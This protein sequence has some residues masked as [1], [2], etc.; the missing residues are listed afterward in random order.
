MKLSGC[1]AATVLAF[2]PSSFALLAQ[3]AESAAYVRFDLDKTRGN[4]FRS[5]EKGVMPFG[6]L[7]KR[8]DEYVDVKIHNEQTFY[9]VNLSI[10]TPAQ[11]VTVLVDTG[12]SD[13]WIIGADVDC[14]PDN[15]DS[16]E[17]LDCFEYGAFD[18][19]KSSSWKNNH[20]EFYISYGD[21]SFA[22]GEWGTDKLDLGDLNADGLTFAVATASNS[23][24]AV[25]GIGLTGIEVTRASGDNGYEYD[26]LPIVLKRNGVID[27]T[28]YSLYLNDLDATSG[29]VLFG[30]VDHSKYTGTLATVPLVN[31]NARY[32]FPKPIELHITLNGL[33]FSSGKKRGT[34]SATK[35]PAL[36]DS[37]TTLSY[38][39]TELAAAI[40]SN[41]GAVWNARLRKFLI[42]CSQAKRN[43]IDLI[44][45]FGGVEITSPLVNYLSET[46]VEDVCL[47]GIVP[48]SSNDIILG[49]VFL[50][51]VYTVYDL[52]A[53]E[54]SIAQAAY[55]ASAEKENIEV[56]KST[57]PG[58]TKAPGYSN[59]WSTYAPISTGGN[60]FNA[61]ANHSEESQGQ[62]LENRSTQNAAVGLSPSVIFA[63]PSAVLI[64]MLSLFF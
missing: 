59:T 19:S 27:K 24:V 30:A 36:L 42:P 15:S 63:F 49:D 21:T 20:T 51:S 55:G 4:D 2:V 40:A 29:S 13:L 50:T 9:S 44:Y 62:S 23:S 35:V 14:G 28:A 45:N 33:G 12:S 26:N 38:F 37:G 18:K 61:A 57:V 48:T 8:D 53:L 64:G 56:I 60:M 52:E 22:S 7:K 31:V 34:I 10:G 5:S 6:E 39:P 46:N 58:A 32:G 11:E 16:T 17:P 43:N 41:V 1:I 47:L 25:L 54:V 3:R